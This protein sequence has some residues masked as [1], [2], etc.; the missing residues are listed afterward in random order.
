M[1]IKNVLYSWKYFIIL[2][3]INV[4]IIL[5]FKIYPFIIFISLLPL[6]L[7]MRKIMNLLGSKLRDLDSQDYKNNTYEYIGTGSRE[8][9]STIFFSTIKHY[10]KNIQILILEGKQTFI[11]ILILI[12]LFF[13]MIVVYGLVHIVK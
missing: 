3:I 6:Q 8:L 4:F 5:F 12:A 9:N 10:P 13:I 7:K 1:K 2:I 11:Q